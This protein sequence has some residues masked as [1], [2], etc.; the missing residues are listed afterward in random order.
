LDW[1]IENIS[2]KDFEVVMIVAL[3]TKTLDILDAMVM[4]SAIL[5]DNGI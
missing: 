4:F 2:V 1:L 5:E 3:N